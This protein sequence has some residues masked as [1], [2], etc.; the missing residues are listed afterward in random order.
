M[1]LLGHNGEYAAFADQAIIGGAVFK[2]DIAFAASR[3]GEQA[4]FSLSFKP[5]QIEG[6]AIDATIPNFSRRGRGRGRPA[7]RQLRGLRLPGSE[8]RYRTFPQSRN[9]RSRAFQADTRRVIGFARCGVASL[10]SLELGGSLFASSDFNRFSWSAPDLT[11]VS[12]LLPGAYAL[13]SLSGTSTTLSVKRLLVSVSGYTV[14]GSGKVDYSEAGRLGFEANLNLKDIPYAMKGSVAGQ[15]ISISG[16]YGLEVSARTCRQGY[17]RLGQGQG[18]SACPSRGG[19]FLATVNA[20]GRFSSP[21]DWKLSVA[22]FDLRPHRGKSGG[23]P[24]AS[25][26][27]AILGRPRPIGQPADRG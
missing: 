12:N 23:H 9:P 10:S 8:S 22:E 3:K 2:K 11:V 5:P 24:G 7:S 4:D 18:T 16:D 26:S 27:R 21:Q 20:E 1:R 6:S 14:E 15:G 19:L 25:P 13:L 17:L